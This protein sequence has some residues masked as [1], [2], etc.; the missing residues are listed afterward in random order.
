MS[1]Q[2][3]PLDNQIN[4][5]LDELKR[6]SAYRTVDRVENIDDEDCYDLTTNDYYGFEDLDE[7]DLFRV[8]EEDK[9][10]SLQ[11]EIFVWD[12]QEF[13]DG[14]STGSRLISG[15]SQT[16]RNLE[17]KFAQQ[18]TESAG[19]PIEC[20]LFNS[21]YHANTGIIPALCKLNTNT[22]VIMDQL[23]HASIIDGVKLAGC[24]FKRFKHNDLESLEYRL[25]QAIKKYENIIICIESIYSMD[26]DGFDSL[27]E[28]ALLKAK[29][30]DQAN[31]ILY[32]DEAH[33]VG[34]FGKYRF[35]RVED[36]EVL[37]LFDLI[38][39][40][41]GKAINAFGCLAFT[42]PNLKKYLVNTCRS[43]IYST[44]LPPSIASYID[45]SFMATRTKEISL[46]CDR[47]FEESNYLRDSI[48]EE[49]ENLQIPGLSERAEELVVGDYQITGLILGDNKAVLEAKRYFANEKIK[50]SAIRYPTVAI[51]KERI[52]FA[53]QA[54]F[55]HEEVNEIL[56]TF[57]NFIQTDIFIN[58]AK[59]YLT[60]NLAEV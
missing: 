42:R 60:N 38:I 55:T 31:I 1:N 53:L 28:V 43:F 59:N 32:C 37:N 39:C 49:I 9:D 51:G 50:V 54:S 36:E 2:P 23:V 6:I 12:H 24:A 41:L 52:R 40:P 7:E 21:G 57:A 13:T 20:L 46:A 10:Y 22:C 25:Q 30:Q 27:K 14:G 19:T 34:L 58:S 18:I 16:I 56:E 8:V 11:K 4:E 48:I 29:Y 44:A 15:N 45:L 3:I 17:Y 35:G 47:L 5:V 33:A 26:G